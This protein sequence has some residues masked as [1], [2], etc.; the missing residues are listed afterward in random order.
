MANQS[1]KNVSGPAA[2]STSPA[3]TNV[4]FSG[5]LTGTLAGS[6]LSLTYTSPP[7]SVA[8]FGNCFAS[9]NGSAVVSGGTMSGDLNVSFTSCEGLGLQAPANSQLT[10]T[11][12]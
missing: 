4:A 8:G 2:V 6:Q 5:T 1:G 7:G 12:Q 3:V 9:G 10:L 11:R